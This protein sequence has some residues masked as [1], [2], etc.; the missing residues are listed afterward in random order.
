MELTFK[1]KHLNLPFYCLHG[2]ESGMWACI[3]GFIVVPTFGL[4]L[5]IE[6]GKICTELTEM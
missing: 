4:F 5:T 1:W 3:T 2:S 6:F